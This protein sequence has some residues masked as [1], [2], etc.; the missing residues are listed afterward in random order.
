MGGAQEFAFLHEP[1]LILLGWARDP[2]LRSSGSSLSS[3]SLWHE[4][5]SCGGGISDFCS[6]GLMFRRSASLHLRQAGRL[7]L[8]SI[9]SGCRV[10]SGVALNSTC[11][12]SYLSWADLPRWPVLGSEKWRLG[13]SKR[14]R[15]NVNTNNALAAVLWAS[16]QWYLPVS[17]RTA[18]DR[19]WLPFSSWGDEDSEVTQLV[20]VDSGLFNLKASLFTCLLGGWEE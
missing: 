5:T 4:P 2:T 11:G 13:R 3:S 20:V 15:T 9:P 8:V 18:R 17:C 16:H 12:C 19:P 14:G 1:Q 10:A 6:C 7:A